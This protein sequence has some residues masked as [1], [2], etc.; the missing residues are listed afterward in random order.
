MTGPGLAMT[1]IVLVSFAGVFATDATA[2]PIT[3]N[4]ALPISEGQGILRGQGLTVRATED[5]SP[6]DRELRGIASPFVLASA[7]TAKKLFGKRP[8]ERVSAR[9]QGKLTSVSAPDFSGD[10]PGASIDISRWSSL[11]TR[12]SPFTITTTMPR[13]I[14]R[15][16]WRGL[17][18]T[19]PRRRRSRRRLF[20][21]VPERGGHGT[22]TAGGTVVVDRGLRS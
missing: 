2:G 4:T 9:I 15:K 6:A 22:G 1:L 10:K 18:N 21:S 14:L 19:L 3:F 20:H 5:P 7:P 17:K 8:G 13:T 11:V 12:R 16:R